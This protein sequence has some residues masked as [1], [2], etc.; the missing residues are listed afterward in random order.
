MLTYRN[1]AAF[2]KALVTA[3]RNKGIFVQRI[4]SGETGKGIPDLF[5]ITKGVPMWIELKRVHG[6]IPVNTGLYVTIPWRPGQQAW[7]ND[8][9]SRGVRCLT[10]ACFDNGILQ[11]T[12]E[13]IWAENEVMVG[14]TQ[15]Y[16]DIRSLLA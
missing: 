10:L 5:V 8:V 6:R 13:R 9:Q 3:M 12:H 4:E 11:I 16:K 2:S 15:Y 14:L 1:E 7:L